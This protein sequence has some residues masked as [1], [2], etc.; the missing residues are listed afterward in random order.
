MVNCKSGCLKKNAVVGR[1]QWIIEVEGFKIVSYDE[2]SY[3][4]SNKFKGSCT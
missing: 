2:A 4:W 1:M 3:R